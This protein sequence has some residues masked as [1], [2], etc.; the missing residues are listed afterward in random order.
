MSSNG[1]SSTKETTKHMEV[2]E[3]LKWLF[4]HR[5]SSA[6]ATTQ[7][8]EEGRLLKRLFDQSRPRYLQA[9]NIFVVFFSFP[10]VLITLAYHDSLLVIHDGVGIMEDY[11]FLYVVALS[12]LPLLLLR[13]VRKRLHTFIKEIPS[14][15]KPPSEG[16]IEK[17]V[18]ENSSP[19]LKGWAR[20]TI[21]VLCFIAWVFTG[22]TDYSRTGGWNSSDHL[23]VFWLS[24]AYIVLFASISIAVIGSCFNAM[25]KQIRITDKLASKNLFDMKSMSPDNS[26]GFRSLG[27]LSLAYVYFL[28]PWVVGI[29]AHYLTWREMTT[30]ALVGF[31]VTISLSFFLFFLPI[32]N[33]H[34]AMTEAK[35]RT[36][37]AISDRY[38]IVDRHLM[39]CLESYDNDI[40]LLKQKDVVELLDNLY[41][42]AKNIPTWPFSRVTLS[43]FVNIS[44]SLPSIS[45]FVFDIVIKLNLGQ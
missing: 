8:I 19:F 31:P 36:L 13:L 9:L 17:L 5:K 37:T 23:V 3:L 24:I 2:G 18:E 38:A 7:Y 32:R 41:R 4:D 33:I 40:E 14:F 35:N 22:F 26:G 43:K 42:K 20:K 6:M 29:V 44:I 45:Y 27:D 15:T 21:N 10:I 25:T 16:N 30:G 28:S 39:D 34:K 1:E 11:L 12:P